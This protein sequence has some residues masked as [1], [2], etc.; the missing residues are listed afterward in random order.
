MTTS[1]SSIQPIIKWP[2]SK[3]SVAALIAGILPRGGTYFEPFLGGG[4][5]LALRPAKRAIAGDVV[6][7][8]LSLWELIRDCPKLVIEAYA[9]RWRRLQEEGHTAFY[10][11]RDGFNVSRDPN[12]LLFLSRTCVNGLIRFNRRGDFNNSLHH[13]RPGIAPKRLAAIVKDWS[14]RTQ[15]VVFQL[16]DYR[17]TLSDAAPGDVAFLDPPYAGTRG[18]YHPIDFDLEVMFEELERLN[19]VGVKWVLTLDGEAGERRYYQ[20]VPPELYRFQMSVPTGRSPFTRLMKSSL[21]AVHESVFANF[22]PPPELVRK[23]QEPR[24]NFPGRVER[25][26]VNRHPEVVELH[27]DGEVQLASDQ[28][29][30]Q[31]FGG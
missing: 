11:I 16:A 24:D 20:E 6:P 12:D 17:V 4:A 30:L 27:S 23:S 31:L 18:R 14:L 1:S 28:G 2:G 13:T 29:V 3:R 7:E 10:E 19:E 25:S 8:L 26:D 9:L 15:D 21:D 5:V 22:D